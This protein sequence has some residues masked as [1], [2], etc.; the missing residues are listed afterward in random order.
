MD[1]KKRKYKH[2]VFDIDG[3]LLD[4]EKAVLLSLQEVVKT[5]LNKKLELTDLRFALGIPGKDALAILK[6]EDFD[7][8]NNL[9]IKSFQ[10]YISSIKLFDGIVETLKGLQSK[11][12]VL[13]IITSKT[14]EEYKNDFEPFGISKY[15]NHVVCAED[16][17]NHKPDSEPM[18]IYLKQSGAESENVL[19]IGDTIY[20]RLC[21]KGAKVDFALALWGCKT[22]QNINPDIIFN[23]PL[24]IIPYL[25]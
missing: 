17:V 7:T 20:D 21:A 12:F 11:G 4:T 15:F 5:V 6:I 10:K 8:A 14:R 25:S 2:I 23:Y 19:Y 13:G 3:T 1:I 22:P 16:S 18:K 24:D 9:W